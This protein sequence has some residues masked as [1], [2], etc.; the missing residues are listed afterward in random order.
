MK[1]LLVVLVLL[2]GALAGRGERSVAAASNVEQT[3]QQ[4]ILA[5]L[6]AHDTAFTL[7]VPSSNFAL[8][9]TA[10]SGA[11]AENE[12]MRD[13][14]RSSRWDA[15]S[16]GNTMTVMFH[17][18]YY[19]TAAQ[20]TYVM[21]TVRQIVDKITTPSM[22]DLQKEKAIHDYLVLHLAYDVSQTHYS[23]YDALTLGVT[24]CQGYTMLAYQM[25][26][27]VGIPVHIVSGVADGAS[28]TWNLV[29]IQG[30]WYNLDVTW[31]DPVPNQP[32]KVQYGYF[33]LTDAQLARTHIWSRSG[34]PPATTDFVGWL[35]AQGA[36][37]SAAA[38]F[39][40]LLLVS[41]GLYLETP[42]H[43]LH[44]LQQVQQA[45]DHV[46]SCSIRFRY[47]LTRV[48]TDLAHAVTTRAFEATFEQ[49][50][51]SPAY[52]LV[53]LTFACS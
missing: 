20:Y 22:T 52:A 25:L 11:L 48:R 5:H 10:F 13:D 29:E 40:R 47:P 3:L 31:D 4:Q 37:R 16:L 21:H 12:Y 9:K 41:T 33:N 50:A 7:S 24:V 36:G 8:I 6:V 23:P 14:Y 35:T 32:G 34:L 42:A 43:T 18:Q 15:S 26:K 2:V 49:D 44:S 19:E 27:D 51:R 46:K 30:N 28:H 1:R 38:A 45:V 53:T 17:L 39:D